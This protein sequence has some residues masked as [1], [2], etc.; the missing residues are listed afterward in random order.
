M[1]TAAMCCPDCGED[2]LLWDRKSM[3]DQVLPVQAVDAADAEHGERGRDPLRFLY[4]V[5]IIGKALDVKLGRRI[6][7]CIP[8][9]PL[10]G[11]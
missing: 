4:S 3:P 9:R 2:P 5:I 1:L 8:L 6:R 7:G 10:R 11:S